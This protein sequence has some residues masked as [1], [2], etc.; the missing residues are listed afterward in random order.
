MKR[1]EKYDN[2]G[3]GGDIC[4]WWWMHQ[5]QLPLMAKIARMVLAIPSSSAKS[6]RVFSTGSQTVTERR[7]NLAPSK[8]EE[9][10]LI[11]ENRKKVEDF[12]TN[13][14]YK[15]KE[16]GKDVFALV[17]V[18]VTPGVFDEEKEDDLKIFYED[19]EDEDIEDVLEIDD[20]I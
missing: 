19:I 18:N 7:G 1:Y 14:D 5:D 3:R 13:S 4:A 16:I 2:P 9:L 11:K 12:K 20:C 8:V 6:K 17:E 15:L 10:I